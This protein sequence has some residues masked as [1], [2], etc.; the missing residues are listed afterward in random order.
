MEPLTLE[1]AQAVYKSHWRLLCNESLN[2][3]SRMWERGFL[4]C[5]YVVFGPD[6]KLKIE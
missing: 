2:E 3:S 1:E 5:L 6:V 4:D